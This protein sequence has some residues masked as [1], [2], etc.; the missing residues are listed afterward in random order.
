MQNGGQNTGTT[1]YKA[2]SS[3]DVSNSD[4]V[5]TWW[6]NKIRSE[7]HLG[8]RANYSFVDPGNGGK[9]TPDPLGG[10]LLIP[11]TRNSAVNDQNGNATNTPLWLY[12]IPIIHVAPTYHY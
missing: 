8:L 2:S 4:K 12:Y 9:W 6:E 3:E 7:N 5:A 1:W 10:V 11:G